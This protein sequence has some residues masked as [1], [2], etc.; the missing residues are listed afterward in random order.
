MATSTET[1]AVEFLD[2]GFMRRLERLS[3]VSRRIFAGRM[4]GERLT[5]RRGESVEFADYR[6]YV[7]GDDLR[8]LDWNIYARLGQLFLKLFLQ[9]EDLHVSVLFDQSRSMDWGD[10][11]KWLY[12]RRL[13]ASL[14]YIG[15]INQDRVSLYGYADGLRTELSGVRG[16]R[17]MFKVIDLLR[18]A[19]CDGVSDLP[20]ACKQFAVRH[21]Q[22]GVVVLLGDFFEKRGYEEGLRYLLGR[23]YD[24]F[25]VQILSPQEID[26]PL[27]G[28][29]QLTDLE[30]GD[31]AEV[32]VS[33]ALL[34]RYRANLRAYC[35]RLETYCTARGIR[36]LRTGTDVP[37]EQVVLKYFRVRGLVQ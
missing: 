3:L 36:Y 1:D 17:M 15:L 6:N 4:R 9:E 21:P 2:P 5:K 13:A 22:P 26:P 35:G 14:A 19:A 32:T 18:D 28:D 23:R 10:P 30:D 33:R 25:V 31:V 27:M 16:R 29:L 12:A 8:F 24:I 34:R 37:F 11:S 20:A 7:C